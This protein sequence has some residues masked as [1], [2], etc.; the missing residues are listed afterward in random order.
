[1]MDTIANDKGRSGSTELASDF[2]RKTGVMAQTLSAPLIKRASGWRSLA[3][4]YWGVASKYYP[5]HRGAAVF[6]LAGTCAASPASWRSQ[7]RAE[8]HH[9]DE[10]QQLTHRWCPLQGI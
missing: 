4:K 2:R 8:G 1:M 9:D 3:V 5:P 10:L 7:T 6:L